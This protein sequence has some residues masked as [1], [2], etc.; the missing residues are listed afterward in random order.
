MV[1]CDQLSVSGDR[2]VLLTEPKTTMTCYDRISGKEL[3]HKELE[4]NTPD[5]YLRAEG[6]YVFMMHAKTFL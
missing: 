3:W 2:I 1:M 6:R 5:S 4:R